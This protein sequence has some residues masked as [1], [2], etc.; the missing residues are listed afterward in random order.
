MS[1]SKKLIVVAL[2]CM[3]AGL[4]IGGIGFIFGGRPGFYV[5]ASG[6]HPASSTST[7]DYETLEK[8]K[9]GAF[10]SIDI[11]LNNAT[12][13][14]IP[15]D[16]YYLEYRLLKADNGKQTYTVS[17][18]TFTFKGNEGRSNKTFLN[19]FSTGPV[20]FGNSESCYFNL[21]VPE[22][23]YFEHV[24]IF[25]ASGDVSL[26]DLKAGEL[27]LDLSFGN[28]QLQ[29]AVADT[30]DMTLSS[31]NMDAVSIEAKR[32]NIEDYFGNITSDSITAGTADISLNSGDL[33]VENMDCDTLTLNDSFGNITFETF[34]NQSAEI[35][36]NSGDFEAGN[37]KLV[38]VD[39]DDSFGNVEIRFADS[40]DK[41]SLDLKT[42][43][44]KVYLDGGSWSGSNMGEQFISDKGQDNMIVIR[45][46]SGD[47]ELT[48]E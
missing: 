29:K 44:G 23:V 42:N 33:E 37:A 18:D 19:F 27:I 48:E 15:S 5:N 4:V 24:N 46:S 17:D 21:Y 8:T 43:F 2:A 45:C 6:I 47:I 13:K 32:L 20:F 28:L 22:D 35:T 16:G 26:C 9:V 40:L 10:T 25:S 38:N 41:Y 31:G 34:V 1:R 7:K 30:M 11:E 36:L 14:L 39:I 12:V 3:A